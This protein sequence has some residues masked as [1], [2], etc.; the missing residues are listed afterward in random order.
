MT[1]FFVSI[2]AF[3]AIMLG[4]FAALR[5]RDSLHLVLG[6]SA[7][8]VLAVAFFDLMP[9]AIEM[10]GSTEYVL[11]LVV[12]GFL[13]Y[14]L[15]DRLLMLGS[16]TDAHGVES[17]VAYIRG[18]ARAGSF[19]LHGF[20]DGV[21]IGL[22]FHVS[23]A[24]GIVVALAVLTHNFSD[25]INMVSIAV[26]HGV[27]RTRA[28][29]WLLINASAPFLGVVAALF[30]TVGE[31][32]LGTLLAL[33]AGFFLYISTSDLIP[34]SHHTHSTFWTTTMTLL[35]ALVLFVVIRAVHH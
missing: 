32:L 28:L 7:G 31:N 15:F 23:E 8:A 10:T 34:E 2:I 26:R 20:L 24:A 5:M 9:E 12:L 11:G 18:H 19:S 4:G 3:G 35:G 22:A 27:G 13:V 14:L 17:D 29:Q 30:V 16:H 21:A 6:F 33:F 1:A 25:G